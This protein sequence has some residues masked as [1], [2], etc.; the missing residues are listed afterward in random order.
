MSKK[1]K[2]AIIEDDIAIV[3]M[4]RMKFETEGYEV[5][6]A[7]NGEDGLKL[8]EEEKP[9]MVL[10]DLMMPKMTGDQMLEK[11]RQAEFGK[12]LPVVV[13]TNMGENEA[14][15]SVKKNGVKKFIVK[16]SM[17]PKDVAGVVKATLAS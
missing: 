12:D 4:Y 16:A 7:S 1:E 13:L 8:V 14:P 5:V 3:Q 10:L 17:T 6:T 11:L 9:D 2:I 15:A